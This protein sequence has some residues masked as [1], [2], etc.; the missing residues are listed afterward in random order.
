MNMRWHP[1]SEKKPSE[2][3]ITLVYG[4]LGMDLGVFLSGHWYFKNGDEWSADTLEHWCF[5]TPSHW[6]EID[7]PQEIN[8]GEISDCYQTDEALELAEDADFEFLIGEM[9]TLVVNLKN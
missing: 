9:E 4:P 2:R 8:L 7:S 3:K 6:A 1:F 5:Y